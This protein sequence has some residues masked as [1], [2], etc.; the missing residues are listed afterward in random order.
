MNQVIDLQ[1]IWII[2]SIDLYQHGK[3]TNAA[4]KTILALTTFLQSW[5]WVPA[6]RN[7]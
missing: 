7:S 4:E 2:L 5:I 6:Q 3:F 1:V